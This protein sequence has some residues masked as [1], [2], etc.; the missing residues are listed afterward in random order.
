MNNRRTIHINPHDEL[1]EQKAAHYFHTLQN[2]I[3]HHSHLPSLTQK[4]AAWGQQHTSKRSLTSLFHRSGRLPRPGSRETSAYIKWLQTTGKLDAYLDRSISYIFLR[5]LGKSLAEPKTLKRVQQV[6]EE[7]KQQ[8]LSSLS[9]GRSA[10]SDP[11]QKPHGELFHTVQLY[12]WAQQE[13]I[14]HTFIWVMDKLRRVSAQLPEEMDAENAQRKLVKI[15]MG[16]VLHVLEDM[17]ED[18]KDDQTEKYNRSEMLDKAIRLGYCYGLTYPFIDD[19]LDSGVLSREEKSRF[20]EII[21]ETLLTG[22]VAELGAWSGNQAEL[23]RFI[24]A[25]LGEAFTYMKNHQRPETLA[26]FLQQAYVF[27]EA[28]ETDRVKELSYAHYANEE[29]YLPIMIKSASSRS[30]VRSILAS[31]EDEGFDNRTF[32]YGIYNQLADDFADLSEDLEQGAVTP[33]TY[34][35][36]HSRHRDDLINP[37]DMYWAVISHL[38]HDVYEEDPKTCDI[39]LNRAINGL[40]R[41]RSRVG[42]DRY[43]EVMQWFA[44]ANPELLHLIQ[45]LVLKTEQADFLD[46]LMRDQ[47]LANLQENRQSKS[48]FQHDIKRVRAHINTLLKIGSNRPTQEMGMQDTIIEAA[49]YSLEGDGKRLRPIMTWMMGVKEFGL[50]PTAIEPLLKS[51]EYMH[52]ASLILDDLPSQDNAS[53]RRGRPTL[54]EVYD[55]A[56]A[57]LTALYLTQKAT[58]EQASLQSFDAQHVL[59]LIQYSSHLTENMCMGQAMDLNAKEK[60]LTLEQ[61]NTMCFYKTGMGFEAALIMPA[62]LAQLNAGEIAALKAYARHAGI[63]FQI[64]DDL[65]DVEGELHILGKEPGKDVDNQRSTFVS[66]LGREGARAAMWEHYCLALEALDDIPLKTPFLRHLLDFMMYRDH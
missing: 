53:L 11:A 59:E 55:V 2:Q 56:T 62:M 23:I 66:V 37:F 13:G 6:A 1:T 31:S 28:Q 22:T 12:R 52:T 42:P 7:I 49:N 14:A 5:D 34:Y 64:K 17:E 29:L 54:H 46:K 45:R 24:H 58:R 43:D 44:P 39:I 26:S 33:Y 40:K 9:L 30:I 57:D 61:L 15:I 50:T 35:L 4:L 41:F 10:S 8:L 48:A 3:R 27:F 32:F 20:A 25:E 38:I 63:L 21:R 51:L 47:I 16:M 36:T 60:P 18:Q 65:L 19:L